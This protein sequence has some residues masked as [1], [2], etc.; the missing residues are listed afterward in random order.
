ML[1]APLQRAQYYLGI[2][3]M[4]NGIAAPDKVNGSVFDAG[5]LHVS[6]NQRKI[7]HESRRSQMRK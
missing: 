3:R 6:L 4:I 7:V 2:S 5:T 1:K